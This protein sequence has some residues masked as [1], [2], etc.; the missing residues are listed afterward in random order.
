VFASGDPAVSWYSWLPWWYLGSLAQAFRDLP[1][2]VIEL[3]VEL[4]YSTA[5]WNVLGLLGRQKLGLLLLGPRLQGFV[6]LAGA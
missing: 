6:F 4:E 1:R 2:P 5:A 3:G